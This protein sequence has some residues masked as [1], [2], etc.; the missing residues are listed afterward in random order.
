MKL[1]K[2]QLIW[3]ART[4]GSSAGKSKRDCDLFSLDKVVKGLTE[5]P[6]TKICRDQYT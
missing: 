6:S 3:V 2:S 4:S 1:T 5:L